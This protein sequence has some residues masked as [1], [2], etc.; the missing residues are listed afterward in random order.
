MSYERYTFRFCNSLGT[1]ANLD[2][3]CFTL[4]LTRILKAVNHPHVIQTLDVFEDD[5]KLSIVTEFMEHGELFER[6]IE[7]K[8]FTED[9]AREVTR[10]M[11]CGVEHLHSLQIVHR[12]IKPENVLCTKAKQPLSVHWRFQV[13]LTDFG[14]S[15]IINDADNTANALLSHVGTSY[16]L[17][18]EVIGRKGYGPGVDV[19]ACGIVLYVMLSGRFPFWGKSDI[20]FLRSLERG[21]DFAS[22]E[23]DMVSNDGKQFVRTLLT[24]D[25]SRRPSASQALAMPWITQEPSQGDENCIKKLDSVAGIATVL[26]NKREHVPKSSA[27]ASS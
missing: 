13:K 21:P 19:W 7:E 1:S 22:K 10:Q 11:L 24:L 27:L 26:S 14:L 4:H 2:L 23:W 9:K 17:A 3:Q 5:E 15:N 18:P 8:L 12:D 6:I 25:P 20:D 16:Y